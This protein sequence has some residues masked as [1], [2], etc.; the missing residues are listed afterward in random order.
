MFN[1][2]KLGIYTILSITLLVLSNPFIILAQGICKTVGGPVSRNIAEP[3]LE[4]EVIIT[5]NFTCI[6]SGGQM[7]LYYNTSLNPWVM[8]M[9]TFIEGDLNKEGKYQGS[10]PKQSFGEIVFYYVNG[11]N[12]EEVV[13]SQL[14]NYTVKAGAINP[15]TLTVAFMLVGIP[16]GFLIL[17]ALYFQKHPGKLS[18]FAKK[19]RPAKER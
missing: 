18:E 10:I 17:C 19:L 2:K 9:M 3:T 13:I 8:V 12:G 11:T 15:L 4:D 7:V 6:T 1:Y 5:A 14:F 16:I